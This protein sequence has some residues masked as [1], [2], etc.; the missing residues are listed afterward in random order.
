MVRKHGRRRQFIFLT[1]D[2]V[3]LNVL[4]HLTFVL[5][6]NTSV[7]VSHSDLLSGVES[8]FIYFLLEVII[9]TAWVASG[10]IFRL[11]GEKPREQFSQEALRVLRTLA[12][13]MGVV[14]LTIV[15]TRL[16]ITAY[17]RLFLFLFF[18]I[19]ALGLIFWR[20]SVRMNSRK[21]QDSRNILVVGAGNTGARFYERLRVNRDSGYK[22]IGFLD[23]NG[24]T[25]KV[26]PM[27]LGK[28]AILTR[29]PSNTRSTK[30][31]L[32]CLR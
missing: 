7:P 20:G 23:N 4:Y 25:S 5:R 31:S 22:V 6:F 30:L 21:T 3:V 10:I 12:G 27:I 9:T 32:R 8:P 26:R 1:T 24:V 18:G 16:G 29:L 17:S 2:L 19:A 14:F 28:S 11:Y 13:V 15:F